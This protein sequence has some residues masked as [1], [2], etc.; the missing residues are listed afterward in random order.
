MDERQ[1]IARTLAGDEAAARAL[2]DGHADRAFGLAYRLTGDRDLAEDVVQD[3]FL[4]AFD[5]L[6]GF[7]GDAAFSSWLHAITVS[8]AINTLRKR[9]RRRRHEQPWGDGEPPDGPVAH[10][11]ETTRRVRRAIDELPADLRALVLLHYA[12]GY[13]HRELAELLNIPEG[14]SKARLARAR[15]RVRRSLGFPVGPSRDAPMHIDT[16]G[17]TP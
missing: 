9:E 10:D 7:R 8:V 11:V 14:T 1:L 16:A 6:P 2:Y 17:G 13:K 4:R 3:A 15:E 12:E 5:R